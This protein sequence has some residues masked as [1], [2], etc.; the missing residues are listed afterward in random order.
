[1]DY[2]NT[3]ILIVNIYSTKVVCSLDVVEALRQCANR[4]ICTLGAKK[5]ETQPTSYPQKENPCILTK[6]T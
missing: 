6:I 3:E 4:S 1:M 5:A 2:V